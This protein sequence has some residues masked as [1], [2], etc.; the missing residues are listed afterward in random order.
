MNS[1]FCSKCGAPAN[2][3]TKFC[4]NCGNS[5]FSVIAQ[6]TAAPVQP[7]QQPVAPVAPIGQVPPA[8]P[9]QPPKNGMPTWLKV[10]IIIGVIFLLMGGCVV[11]GTY[12]IGKKASDFVNDVAGD[13]EENF[14]DVIEDIE[15]EVESQIEEQTQS[16]TSEKGLGDTFTFDNLEITVGSTAEVFVA[17]ESVDSYEGKEFI[18]VPLTIKNVGTDENRFKSYNYSIYFGEDYL[19]KMGTIFDDSV[20]SSDFIGS[21]ETYNAN[22]YFLYEGDGS[23]KIELNNYTNIV[24]IV[25]DVTK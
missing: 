21:G 20:E 12:Y 5:E 17:D 6:A 15:E 18:K 19:F 16:N 13:L 9:V 1:K 10:L 3:D 25:F 24:N 23:Y 8:A 14:G 2:A 4:T 7:V 22:I 11:V